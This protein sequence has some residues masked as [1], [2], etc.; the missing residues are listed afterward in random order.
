MKGAAQ[1]GRTQTGD[2]SAA[3]TAGGARS[4]RVTG[5]AVAAN[6]L[7]AG[8][9]RQLIASGDGDLLR[10]QPSGGGDAPQSCAGSEVA[11][12]AGLVLSMAVACGAYK[13]VEQALLGG[14]FMGGVLG[15][16]LDR[17]EPAENPGSSSPSTVPSAARAVTVRPAPTR[18]T[19]WWW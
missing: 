4:P 19:R 16:P 8:G 11:A 2:A 7:P 17:G 5:D 3:M 13:G 14:V 6:P 1:R 9:P 18:S 15:V 10:S 12:G